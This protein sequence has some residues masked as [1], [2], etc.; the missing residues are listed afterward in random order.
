MRSNMARAADMDYYGRGDERQNSNIQAHTPAMSSRRAEIEAK[1]E[2]SNAMRDEREK[3]HQDQ[4]ARVEALN[5][6][7]SPLRL[8]S[9]VTL[10]GETSESDQKIDT[11]TTFDTTYEAPTTDTKYTDDITTP[12]EP[13]TAPPP[14]S[15]AR[16]NSGPTPPPWPS[17]RPRPRRNP[18]TSS[19]TPTPHSPPPPP[20]SWAVPTS[21][22]IS[23]FPA[24]LTE[25]QLDDLLTDQKLPLPRIYEHQQSHQSA[26]PPSVV[27]A[28]LPPGRSAYMPPAPPPLPVPPGSAS[29]PAD[30]WGNIPARYPS[31][32]QSYSRY[33]HT[34][35][36]DLSRQNTRPSL[37]SYDTDHSSRHNS[38]NRIERYPSSSS[39]SSNQL[40]PTPPAP[41]HRSPQR[42]DTVGRRP[43]PPPPPQ[44]SGS[45]DYFSQ[46]NGNNYVNQDELFDQIENIINVAGNN[47]GAASHSPSIQINQRPVNGNESQL[48]YHAP[49]DQHGSGHRNGGTINGHLS[50]YLA[51]ENYNTSDESDIEAAAGLAAMQM[52][53]AQ[54]EADEARRR[55]GGSGLFSSY[56][57]QQ[58]VQQY[59]TLEVNNE[60]QTSASDS[61]YVPVDM[62]LY[63]GSYEPHFSYGGGPNQLAAGSSSLENHSQPVSSSGSQR[64][65]KAASDADAYDYPTDPIHPFPPFSA[66]ATFGT[67]GLSEPSAIRQR[68]SYDEGDE[69][70]LTDTQTAAAGEPPDMFYHPGM[71]VRRPL[72][73][74]P[75]SEQRRYHRHER[76]VHKL[77]GGTKKSFFCPHGDC[78]RSSGS[79]FTRKEN[80]TGHIRRVHRRVSASSD[81]GLSSLKRE[82]GRDEVA[83]VE[84]IA[85]ER[86]E[87]PRAMAKSKEEARAEKRQMTRV[88]AEEVANARAEEMARKG[89]WM[90]KDGERESNSDKDDDVDE[91]LHKWTTLYTV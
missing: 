10:A 49:L 54:E 89:E 24:T 51:Q 45:D 34:P 90:R 58:P 38:Q 91:L 29:S 62:G 25:D 79:G 35:D 26:Y 9:T 7:I 20:P 36:S 55:S 82:D 6:D 14:T 3:R 61:D 77:H 23:N 2:K 17:R 67:G 40:P 18:A 74:P 15:F 78:K 47:P 52:A 8:P 68:L 28:P 84:L 19:T 39:Q 64:R 41:P 53:E 71:S 70:T 69:I 12:P 30:D 63:G 1:R 16:L 80:L 73:P 37:P 86:S 59:S 50:P 83:Q 88:R 33:S 46:P 72:P 66:N 5:Q 56:T 13:Q 87:P 65:S 21:L 27:P 31:A 4:G 75:A 42:T 32:A 57:S 85:K 22:T 60:Q 43:L 48:S 76:E 81:T 11:L 44:E